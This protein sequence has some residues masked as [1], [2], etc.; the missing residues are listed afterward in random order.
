MIKPKRFVNY[1]NLT[2]FMSAL[3][4]DYKRYGLEELKKRY[5]NNKFRGMYKRYYTAYIEYLYNKENKITIECNE[6][7]NKLIVGIYIYDMYFK[8]KNKNILN[9]SINDAIPEFLKQGFL[10]TSVQEA[11]HA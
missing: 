1:D 9:E 8:F 3:A 10:L 5:A 4:H 6:Y 11:V 2:L 7:P